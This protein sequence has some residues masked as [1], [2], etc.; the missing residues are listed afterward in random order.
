MK[1]DE[2]LKVTERPIGWSK[3]SYYRLRSAS[4][5]FYNAVKDRNVEVNDT[6]IDNI[7]TNIDVII[8]YRNNGYT[9]NRTMKTYISEI[10]RYY[11]HLT[12]RKHE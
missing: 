1:I 7:L 9:Y 6:N 12:N 10:K 11:K 8:E 2:L 3:G 5:R 4:S